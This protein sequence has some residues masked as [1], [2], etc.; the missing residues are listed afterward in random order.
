[1]KKA[2]PIIIVAIVVIGVG[3]GI[4]GRKFF[5][6]GELV[7]GGETGIQKAEIEEKSFTGK[8]KDALLKG[9]SMKCTWKKDD[10]NFATSYIKNQKIYTE[11]TQAGKK[12][13]S[14]MVDDCTY[15]W[16][17]GKTEGFKFCFEPEEGGE[18]GVEEGA[19]PEG[20]S[21]QAPDYDY[22]C[23]PTIV[24]DSKFEPPTN[25]NFINPQEMMGQ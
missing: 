7:P 3:L 12:M 11:M 1:M 24:S 5:Q 4:G 19:I 13:Y 14:I 9:Q 23:V 8:L 6:K 25:I 20:Y 17:Q 22:Q 10:N 2:L 16:E 21:A 18:E 15:S